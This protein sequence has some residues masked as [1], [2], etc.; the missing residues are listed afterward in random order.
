MRN[1]K[2]KKTNLF[3]EMRYTLNNIFNLTSQK[4]YKV[5]TNNN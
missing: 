3:K 4:P 2:R 5:D 1:N